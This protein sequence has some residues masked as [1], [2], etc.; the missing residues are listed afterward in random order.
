MV[1]SFE[2]HIPLLCQCNFKKASSV[3]MQEAAL[4]SLLILTVTSIE[5]CRKLINFKGFLNKKQFIAHSNQSIDNEV[6]YVKADISNFSKFYS[7]WD[8][9]VEPSSPI[10]FL[11][12]SPPINVLECFSDTEG[13]AD[14][15][16]NL[17]IC[18]PFKRAGETLSQKIF[19]LHLCNSC[20][21]QIS[22]ER[23]IVLPEIKQCL[24][25]ANKLEKK[26]I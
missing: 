23:L 20:G 13:D 6:S 19:G 4:T 3:A 1:G 21:Q 12:F 26:E 18:I 15:S 7:T 14:A 22:N 8:K 17:T 24:R 25:C 5:V 11:T 9:I 2:T 16:D 10:G